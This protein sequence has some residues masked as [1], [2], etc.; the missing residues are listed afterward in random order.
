MRPALLPAFLL[1]FALVCCPAA[2]DDHEKESPACRS[3]ANVRISL[4]EAVLRASRVVPGHV[5]EAELE[6]EKEKGRLEIDY[7]VEIYRAGFLFMIE[8]NPL[9]G[10]VEE[11]EAARVKVKKG[12]RLGLL[13][14]PHLS[15]PE[16]ILRAARVVEG[17]VLEAELEIDEEEGKAEFTYE[18]AILKEGILYEVE[19]DARTGA[20]LEVEARTK[21]KGDDEEEEEEEEEE[22]GKEDR[23]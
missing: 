17:R 13:L 2:A 12:R 9:T 8:V 22:E 15:M 7:E 3:L 5:M 23:D 18:L 1:A 11:I 20:V 21:K 4:M 14:A 19:L 6:I 10:R 16:A